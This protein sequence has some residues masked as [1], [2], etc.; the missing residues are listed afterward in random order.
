MKR[1]LGVSLLLS[2]CLI[3]FVAVSR[4]ESPD[5]ALAGSALAAVISGLVYLGASLIFD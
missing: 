1:L 5:A 2:I 3:L 4:A